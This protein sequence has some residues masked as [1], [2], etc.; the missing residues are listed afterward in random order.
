V[1]LRI[2]TKQEPYMTRLAT[3]ITAT[4]LASASP[5]VVQ[6]DY[7][8]YETPRYTIVQQ[9]GP[10]EVR[11]YQPALMAQVQVQASQSAALREGFRI[12]AGY[13]FGGNVSSDKIA[14]TSPVT[15]APSEQIAMTSP[16]TQSGKDGIWTVSFMM[17]H[18]YTLDTLPIP[19]NNAI[20]F[21]ETP[22]EQRVAITFSGWATE[23]RRADFE[24]RL[25]QWANSNAYTITGEA[26]LAYYDD[27]M[28]LPWKRRNEVSFAIR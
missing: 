4:A 28:T 18:V 13:I 10:I 19:K 6:A 8:G 5:A 14:M 17:P 9:V 2:N 1:L 7:R 22:P 23:G 20:Q 16:V 21:I 25:R 12:L 24:N 3:A 11:D 15:Q 26:A 27:P